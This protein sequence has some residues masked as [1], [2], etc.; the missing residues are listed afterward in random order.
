MRRGTRLLLIAV[1]VAAA[2]AACSPGYLLRAAWEEGKILNRRRPISSI[3]AD[4]ATDWETREKLMLVLQAR[5]FAADTLGL[6]AGKSYT[7]FS[8]VDSDTLVMV[9]SAAY[10]DRFQPHTWWFPIVG[11]VPY[12]GF[13][14]FD[15]AEK[16]RRKL[17]A[18]GLDT[19]L[20]PSAAFSTLGW[21]NDP[22][23]STLLRYDHVSLAN[24][25]IH[26]IFH[27][28]YFAPGQAVFNE[29]L[30]NF[31][32]SR[33]AI[34]F[35]CRRDG[36]EAR[37]CRVAKAAWQD[38]LLF[39][40]YLEGLVVELEA[41]YARA[42]LS[43]E[44]KVAERERVFTA[45]QRRF[46]DEVRPR[47]QVDSFAGFTREPLNNATLIARRIYYRR[48]DLFERV[49]RSRGGDF[50]RTLM[51]LIAAA[52]GSK[53]DPYTGVEALLGA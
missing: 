44:Q 46:A 16:A 41:L 24:T 40:A 11:R 36:M 48:L 37:T 34:E 10:K 35:F 6:N 21:F 23:L 13:F 15:D 49:Y 20:R 27:N 9:L 14:D 52:R 51:D 38:D 33:G 53:A 28:T 42:D 18:R 22:L 5:Q 3:V 26:E 50:Q 17:E 2:V 29:S 12:K 47:L 25:V 4:T 39:G 45:A 19:Y 43:S 7:L 1:V 8:R 32:G 30:A 31:V